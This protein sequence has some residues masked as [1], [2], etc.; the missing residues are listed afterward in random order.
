[1]ASIAP[2]AVRPANGSVEAALM[3]MLTGFLA[4]APTGTA[5][6][7]AKVPLP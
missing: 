7:S 6:S 1:M 4:T 2:S 5:T 3:S